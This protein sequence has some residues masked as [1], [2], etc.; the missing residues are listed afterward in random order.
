MPSRPPPQPREPPPAF[1]SSAS[2]DERVLMGVVAGWLML[3]ACAV[4]ALGLALPGAPG[5]HSA[6]VLGACMAVG[7]Y[8]VVC[9]LQVIDWRRLS[10]RGH[11]W[12]AAG[13]IAVVGPLAPWAACGRG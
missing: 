1:G 11:A 8:G 5:Q 12:V 2:R 6:I 7:A 3:A 10:L 9:V 4:T 13:I